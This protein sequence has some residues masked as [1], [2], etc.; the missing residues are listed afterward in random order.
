MIIMD[1]EFLASIQYVL[2]N[3]DK[4]DTSKYQKGR[5]SFFYHFNHISCCF[6]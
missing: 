5:T 6:Q 3:S 4:F 2:L 1:I